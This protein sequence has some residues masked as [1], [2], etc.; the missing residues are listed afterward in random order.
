MLAVTGGKGGCGKTT[1]A[2]G[3]AAILAER[4]RRPIVVEGDVDMP[5]L[6][7]RADADDDGIDRLAAGDSIPAAVSESGRFPGVDVLGG[8]PGAPLEAALRSLRT[9]RPVVLDG[10]AGASIRS[11]LPLEYATATVV[12]TRDTPASITDAEKT[13]RMARALETP[14]VATVVSRAADISRTIGDTFGPSDVVAVPPVERPETHPA[15]RPAYDR[16][17]DSWANA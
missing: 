11:V 9:D 8:R 7:I 14:I 6:H 2:L 17:V 1:T 13:V 5:N 15:A 16:V 12:V 4:R 10:V 3:V